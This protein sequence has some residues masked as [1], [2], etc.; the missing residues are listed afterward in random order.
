MR[1]DARELEGYAEPITIDRLREGH[2]Y[3]SVQYADSKLLVPIVQ[4]I[5]FV[6]RD[7]E[8]ADV[9]LYYFQGYESFSNGIQYAAAT[10]EDLADFDARG[11]EDL[12][13]IFEF[14]RALDEL[15]RCSLRQRS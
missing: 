11:P 2:V 14:E 3:F 4:P 7:L 6:G 12:N 5:V 8:R 10:G 1:F 9:D 15:M 13:H